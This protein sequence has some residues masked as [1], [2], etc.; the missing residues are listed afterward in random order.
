M[1]Q[2]PIAILG[3]ACRVPQ[4]DDTEAFW[5]NLLQG[6]DCVGRVLPER[7]D[8]Q[9]LPAD[10]P[11]SAAPAW[12]DAAGMIE[13]GDC[14]DAAFFDIKPEEALRV[15][16]QQGMMLEMAW[17]ACEDAG[18]AP[19]TLAGRE[20]G[21]YI[22]ISTRDFDRRTANVWAE[23]AFQTATGSCAAMAANRLSYVFGLTGP[24]V[25]IDTACAS[26]LT[27]L[28]QA[29][30]ALHD[31]ECEM[32]LVGGV[33]LMLSPTNILA[34]S[35]DKVLS[36]TGSCKPFAAQ[37][38][39]YVFSDGGGMVL[40]KPLDVALADGDKIRAVI[41]GSAVNHNGRSNG[42]T[43]PYGAALQQVMRK[44]LQRA[45]VNAQQVGYVEAHAVGTPIGDAIEMQAI[46]SVYATGR[47]KPCLVGSVKGNI[48]HLEAASG[49]AALVKITLALER[50]KLPATVHCMPRSPLLRLDPQALRI[51][52]TTENWDDDRARIAALSAFGFGGAN[53][54]VILEQAPV[55]T[56]EAGHNRAEGPWVLMV[57]ARTVAAFRM[58]CQRYARHL[59]T[60]RQS[61]APLTALRDFCRATMLTRQ[62]HVLRRAIPVLDWFDAID[63]LA[64][65][66]PASAP[67]RS[68]RIG[69]EC[70]NGLED[71]N[72]LMP[73]ADE[74][75]SLRNVCSQL[76][77]T[78]FYV[79]AI[80]SEEER[81]VLTNHAMREGMPLAI[82]DSNA[83]PFGDCLILTDAGRPDH[84]SDL[85]WDT[86]HAWQAQRSA[87]VAQL[88]EHGFTLANKG[89]DALFPGAPHA[90]PN[91]P[92]ERRRNHVLHD[93]LVPAAAQ[94]SARQAGNITSLGSTT[95]ETKIS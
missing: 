52:E 53:A 4:A 95:Q 20:V 29:C 8:W 19:D 90:L 88:Y 11:D 57:S 44:A 68:C 45:G 51:C 5:Q 15:D 37:A 69:I 79:D 93:A 63:G 71:C 73:P 67:T 42:L 43:A 78:R 34:F 26:S 50:G 7:W 21:V 94:A 16:P 55:V 6:R 31:G 66:Q 32:A 27:A 85:R 40:L 72:Y 47:D 83:P 10:A 38:D 49:I 54:H 18:I 84:L 22:G 48:G 91:Y 33:Q 64:T 74:T 62:H 81:A 77:I 23:L 76:G 36:K 30:R 46:G 25:C 58:L 17:H 70:G 65:A 3:L 28:H 80:T 14:Y 86:R 2:R 56:C 9:A 41:R 60:V 1:T 87:L 82:F 61:G 35:R 75:D 13:D 12:R 24:S 89:L 39:G 92:F 59:S